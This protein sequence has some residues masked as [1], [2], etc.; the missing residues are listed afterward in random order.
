MSLM[1]INPCPWLLILPLLHLLR[2]RGTTQG[3]PTL[4]LI[5]VCMK[6]TVDNKFQPNGCLKWANNLLIPLILF[7]FLID[8][9]PVML[10]L[11]SASELSCDMW[12][13]VSLKTIK[14]IASAACMHL[15]P[16]PQ[17]EQTSYMSMHL[18]PVNQ[19]VY[20]SSSKAYNCSVS[21]IYWPIS[22]IQA[23]RSWGS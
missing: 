8:F 6:N 22:G 9:T 14:N 21:C 3:V 12:Y 5:L 19:I 1:A 11:F 20:N 17:K 16:P 4:S 2:Q 10:N 18:F 23:C 15:R 7:T 13:V